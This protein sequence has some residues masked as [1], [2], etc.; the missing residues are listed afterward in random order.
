MLYATNVLFGISQSLA[1]VTNSPFLM[2]NSG[3]QERTYLFS[4]SSGL[5]MASQS[6]GNWIG[7][8]MP[9]WVASARGLDPMSHTGLRGRVV[10]YRRG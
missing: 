8:V 4:F 5:Q 9:G 1:A 7:G 2:E 10:D 3:E 6:V